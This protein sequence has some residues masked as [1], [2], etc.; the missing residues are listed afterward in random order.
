MPPTVWEGSLK[1]ITSFV[2]FR[3]Q[4]TSRI[5]IYEYRSS[6]VLWGLLSS[7]LVFILLLLH[8]F[9][10]SSS[11]EMP[12]YLL[13]IW[14]YFWCVR[15]VSPTM[16]DPKIMK[17]FIRLLL[18]WFEFSSSLEMPLYWKCIYLGSWSENI[19]LDHKIREG[20]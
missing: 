6:T 8:W 17:V 2:V 13:L 20:S 9:E 11:F 7:C 4:L 10:F 14:I 12:L 19:Y 18:H 15:Y 16:R 5:D 3:Y 1:H